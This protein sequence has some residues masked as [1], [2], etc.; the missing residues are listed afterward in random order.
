MPH[1]ACN[2]VELKFAP[3]DAPAEEAMSFAGYGAV[4]SNVDAYGDVIAPG[5]FAQ[6]LADV[7]S[8][9]QSWPAMLSQHG[10]W[11]M[12]AEDMTPVGIWTDLAEDGHGL[13]ISGKLADT[14]RGQELYRLMK[15]SPRPAIDGLSIGYIAKEWEPRSKPEDPRRKLKRIDLVEISPVT[16][17]ANGKARVDAVKSIR[18]AEKALREVGFSQQEAKAIIAGGF[19]TLPQRRDVAGDDELAAIIRRNTSILTQ[20]A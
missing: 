4:F 13:K 16:F 9:R 10:G 19:K 20:G 3:P 12:T 5:A 6:Y 15:M 8:G 11:G 14:P 18:D 17:P 1:L 7:K 2:L